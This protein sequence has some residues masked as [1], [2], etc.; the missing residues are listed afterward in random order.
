[1]GGG[2]GADGEDDGGRGAALK[3]CNPVQRVG[4]ASL[5]VDYRSQLKAQAGSPLPRPWPSP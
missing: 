4:T 2:R 1:M 3:G 5:R